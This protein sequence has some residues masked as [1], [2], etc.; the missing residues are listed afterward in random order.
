MTHT[1]V[2]LKD[3]FFSTKKWFIVSSDGFKYNTVG[4]KTKKAAVA[5]VEEAGWTV[6]TYDAKLDDWKAYWDEDGCLHMKFLVK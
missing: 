4:F 3:D 5:V 6:A 2:V 1:A